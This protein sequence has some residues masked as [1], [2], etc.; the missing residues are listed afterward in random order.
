MRFLAALLLCWLASLGAA[1]DR[2]VSPAEA[3]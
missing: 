3:A 2:V 1:D